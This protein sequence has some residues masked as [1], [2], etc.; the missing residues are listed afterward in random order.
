MS[1]AKYRSVNIDESDRHGRRNIESFELEDDEYHIV[2]TDRCPV[3]R[4]FICTIVSLLVLL[5]VV[6]GYGVREKDVD[7]ETTKPPHDHVTAQEKSMT[8]ATTASTNNTKEMNNNTSDIYDA[9]SNSTHVEKKESDVTTKLVYCYGDSLTYG[10]VPQQHGAPEAHPYDQSLQ[11]EINTL[12][13]NYSQSSIIQVRH[14]GYPGWTSNQMIQHINDGLPNLGVCN[15]IQNNPTISL[16]IILVGTNDIGIMANSGTDK[17]VGGT[18]ADSI[19]ELHKRVFECAAKEK[20]SNIHTMALGIEV[21]I[22]IGHQLQLNW[23]HT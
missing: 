10:M 20:N 4:K 23:L 19:I 6:I 16:I 8:V 15:I 22:K 12:Y 21:V 1:S 17:D 14:F 7:E 13:A 18:I 2:R 11:Q 5:V 9:K 3:R